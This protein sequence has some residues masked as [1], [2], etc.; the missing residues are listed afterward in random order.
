VQPLNGQH[1]C[2]QDDEYR[3][4]RIPKGASIHSVNWWAARAIQVAPLLIIARRSMFRDPVVY[5]TDVDAF[6]PERF[7]GPNPP[8]DPVAVFG[9][10]RRACL[11][12]YF[13]GQ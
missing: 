4:F 8:R 2:T 3:G 5:G 11:G 6:R 13:A 10:G 7:L 9:Y 1:V 12:R